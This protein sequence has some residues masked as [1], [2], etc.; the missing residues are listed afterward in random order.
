MAMRSVVKLVFAGLVA[1]GVSAAVVAVPEPAFAQQR[2]KPKTTKGKALSAAT[3][4]QIE[5]SQE[6]LANDNHACAIQILQALLAKGDGIP[7]YDRAVINQQLGYVYA[8]QGQYGQAIRYFQAALNSNE[9]PPEL[10]LQLQF[11]LAQLLLAEER[12]TEAIRLLEDWFRRTE[13]KT[14]QSYMLLCNAYAVTERYQ[15]ALSYCETGLGMATERREDWH[16]LMLAIYL[17]LRQYSKGLNLLERM[18]G[19][20]PDRKQ[21]WSNLA[22][23]Y[24]ELNRDRDSYLVQRA[25]YEAGM[26]STSRELVRL[27]QLHLFF[28]LPYYAGKL[29]EEE[30][31]RGRVEKTSKNYELLANSWY[32]AREW[33]KA[34][35]ALRE[36]AARSD[37]GDLYVRL[38]SSLIQEERWGE[39]ETALVRGINKGK[40]DQPGEA[41]ILL[42]YAR[43]ELNKFESAKE[44]FQR[45]LRFE[46][47]KER[48]EQ[49]LR[50][51]DQE[52]KRREIAAKEAEGEGTAV[53]E[54]EGESGEAETADKLPDPGTVA[55]AKAL[56]PDE[57][58][59]GD[60]EVPDAAGE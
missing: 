13:T 60:I 58:G 35:P 32:S 14:A 55:P 4:E 36:A 47:T 54:G 24:A 3:F 25:M 29:L 11:N 30:L 38:G 44:A 57:I 27:A 43:V 2:E 45:A 7:A 28:G 6:C 49:Y 16:R 48:A 59:K 10:G 34:I 15:Q 40:L 19:Y 20:W 8:D 31:N 33:K 17:E 50:F 41:W 46:K 42:G 18:V 22:S 51:V 12:Y 26:L 23:I 1:I 52:L 53:A 9:L 21:Y 56:A 5:K 39:A 37:E